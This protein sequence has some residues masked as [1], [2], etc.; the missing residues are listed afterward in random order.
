MPSVFLK[1]I[2]R[3]WRYQVAHK[4]RSMSSQA[5]WPIP[6]RKGAMNTYLMISCKTI[7]NH[8]TRIRSPRT[9]RIF[10]PNCLD[11]SE[12]TFISLLYFWNTSQFCSLSLSQTADNLSLSTA[13]RWWSFTQCRW[14]SLSLLLTVDDLPRAPMKRNDLS[15]KSLI[16]GE[17]KHEPRR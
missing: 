1:W 12:T 8:V 16:A 4:W 7:Y 17:S 11:L 9:A 5:M 6:T 13:N 2:K 3:I 15:L 10:L 14:W